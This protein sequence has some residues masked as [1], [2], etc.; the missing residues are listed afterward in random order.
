MV[1]LGLSNEK[2]LFRLFRSFRSVPFRSVPGFSTTPQDLACIPAGNF[3][4]VVRS[5][6]SAPYHAWIQELA[7]G[8][9]RGEQEIILIVSRSTSATAV[10]HYRLGQVFKCGLQR[11]QRSRVHDH[12]DCTVC[13]RSKLCKTN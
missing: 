3:L 10:V 4:A 12:Y 1:L 2:W 6:E 13:G 7:A 5:M 11:R 9:A 8:T